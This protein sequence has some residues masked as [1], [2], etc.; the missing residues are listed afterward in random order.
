MNI[1]IIPL[2]VAPPRSF[3]ELINWLEKTLNVKFIKEERDWLSCYFSTLG[4]TI[5][6]IGD[7]D[8]LVLVHQRSL[9]KIDIK[10]ETLVKQQLHWY[11]ESGN[12]IARKLVQQN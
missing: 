1:L 5:R 8:Y 7:L 9:S 2:T 10:A 3:E 6:V 4:L 11:S 12:T